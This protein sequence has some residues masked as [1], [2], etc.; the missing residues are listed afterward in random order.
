MQGSKI[1]FRTLF[2]IGIKVSFLNVAF[3][4]KLMGKNSEKLHIIQNH[5]AAKEYLM[6][7]QSSGVELLDLTKMLNAYN[8]D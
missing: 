6:H 5:Q 7:M 1:A 8:Y 3:Q 2:P 4:L